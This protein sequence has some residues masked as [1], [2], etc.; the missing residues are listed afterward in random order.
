MQSKKCQHNIIKF[1]C[2]D[3]KGNGICEHNRR[4]TYCKECGG[5]AICEHNRIKYQCKDCKGSQIC[6][7]NNVKSKCKECDGS[8]I[9][10]HNK[11]KSRCKDCKGGEICEHN[12]RRSACKDCYGSSYCIHN[13]AKS[14]CKE[15]DGKDLCKT[16]LCETRAGLKKYESYCMR[17][18]IH[19]FPEKPNTLNYKTKEKTIADYILSNFT[20]D[21]YTWRADKKIENGCS[22]RRPDL[23]LDL[24]Y[25]VV[26]IEIDENQHQSYDC[27]C[28]NKRI[29]E[30]SLDVG[31]RPI[32]L[33][34]F[35]PDDY[36]GKDGKITSCWGIDGRG[37]CSIKKTKQKEW[38]ERLE[39][40]KNQINYWINPENR[41]NK[42]VEVI[43]LFYD[44]N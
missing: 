36:W 32:I 13:K 44:C 38:K 35:N 4:K 19:L 28:E 34:R 27:S 2:I 14:R 33:I 25:Q 24:A 22:K 43:E 1:L 10:E 26:I 5:G 6:I 29:M 3:C 17:C 40:L 23:L 42:T 39:C 16:P 7:H 9:C 18:F 8:A 20:E 15:C 37:I 12:R 11:E 21:N 41:T 31:H 30:L